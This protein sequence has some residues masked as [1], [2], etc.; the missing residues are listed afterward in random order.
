MHLF[1][2]EL[3]ARTMAFVVLSGCQ[4]LRAYT[5]RSER[6]S[7][8]SIG[9]FGNKWMQY[10]V[11]AST[12]LLLAVVYLPGVNTVFNAVP[13]SALQWASIAPLLLIPAAV[14]ELTKLGLRVAERR[15]KA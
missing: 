7:L 15:R 2:G 12:V 9:V 3:A 8:F 4:L 13:L 5:N 11:A 10:A 6:A 1:G 14:D